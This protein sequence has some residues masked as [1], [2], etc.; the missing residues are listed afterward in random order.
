MYCPKPIPCYSVKSMHPPADRQIGHVTTS[1][2]PIARSWNWQK[3]RNCQLGQMNLVG[4]EEF[5]G[6]EKVPPRRSEN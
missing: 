2:G 3:L 6:D 5:K 1:K 4:L